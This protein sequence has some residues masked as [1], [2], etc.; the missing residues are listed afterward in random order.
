M[1]NWN[2]IEKSQT[3]PYCDVCSKVIEFGTDTVRCFLKDKA[4]NVQYKAEIHPSC[5]LNSDMV[6]IYECDLCDTDEATD[7]DDIIG[8]DGKGFVAC[9]TCSW[10]TPTNECLSCKKLFQVAK[11]T[12]LNINSVC[13]RCRKAIL[14]QGKRPLPYQENV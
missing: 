5:L 12:Q 4:E 7:Y 8:F 1:I 2:E 13:F 11:D 14:S 10:K 9:P 6:V 3:I